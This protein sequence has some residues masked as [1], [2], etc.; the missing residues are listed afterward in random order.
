MTYLVVSPPSRQLEW[1]EEHTE[2]FILLE[3][4]L[5]VCFK[6]CIFVQTLKSF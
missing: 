5:M 4:Q 6:N 3:K 2:L 1:D